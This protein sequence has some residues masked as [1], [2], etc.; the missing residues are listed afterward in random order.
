MLVL[1][2]QNRCSE[3]FIW[4]ATLFIVFFPMMP[5]THQVLQE[6]NEIEAG[7]YAQ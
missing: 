6:E 3:E 1:E 2:K 5:D 4:N 7:H